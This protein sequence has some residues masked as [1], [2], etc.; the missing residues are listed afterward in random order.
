MELYDSSYCQLLRKKIEDTDS[1]KESHRLIN[2][3]LSQRI[4]CIEKVI[5]NNFP[6]EVCLEDMIECLWQD[7]ILANKQIKMTYGKVVNST[8][9]R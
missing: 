1:I 7:L 3:Y 2:K 4:N 6:D 8:N 9:K 5:A